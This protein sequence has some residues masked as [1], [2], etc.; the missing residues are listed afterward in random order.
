METSSS[1]TPY[2]HAIT[3]SQKMS[4][5]ELPLKQK[6]SLYE[7]ITVDNRELY[8]KIS[9]RPITV[10]AENDMEL[11]SGMNIIHVNNMIIILSLS[12]NI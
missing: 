8:H 2:K 1:Y 10:N 6:Y 5:S 9:C 12:T 7:K 11:V 4:I 3:E